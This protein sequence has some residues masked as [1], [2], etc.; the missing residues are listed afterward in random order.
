MLIIDDPTNWA[1]FARVIKIKRVFIFKSTEKWQ[2]SSRTGLIR[3]KGRFAPARQAAHHNKIA[4]N[5][6]E[7][8]WT[9]RIESNDHAPISKAI[10]S[11]KI[12][13]HT[14]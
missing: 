5:C 13:S 7:A 2:T 9:L 14:C 4:T 11:T 6:P 12:I 8:P 10:I 1:A 3:N